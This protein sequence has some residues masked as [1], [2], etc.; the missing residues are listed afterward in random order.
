[1]K[2]RAQRV[3]V[4]WR[5]WDRSGPASEISPRHIGKVASTH[6][7]PCSC[8][9]C[10]KRKSGIHVVPPSERGYDLKDW[11]DYTTTEQA[12]AAPDYTY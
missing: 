5:G 7:R 6:G 2:A 8:W 12:H 3:I 4:H 11:E 9:W 10:C 1:M